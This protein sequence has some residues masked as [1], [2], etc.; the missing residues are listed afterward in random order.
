[1][2]RTTR[3]RPILG[4]LLTPLFVLGCAGSP[5]P[6]RVASPAPSPAD[7]ALRPAAV[8]V[9][10]DGDGLDAAPAMPV[11]ETGQ[12]YDHER[13]HAPGDHPR[14]HAGHVAVAVV[15]TPV[16]LA[17]K[18]VVCGASLVVAAPTAAV[19]ALADGPYGQGMQ[20]LGDGVRYNCGPPYILRPAPDYGLHDHYY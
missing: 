16:F 8:T 13:H 15:G 9:D 10:P 6:A 17:V 7:S 5:E 4:A 2:P 1:M 3:K 20:T 12:A 18:T 11:D 19:L 14:T